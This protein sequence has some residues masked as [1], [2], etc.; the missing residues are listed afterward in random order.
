MSDDAPT[1]ILEIKTDKGVKVWQ[2]VVFKEWDLVKVLKIFATR[3]AI[4]A[5]R[6]DDCP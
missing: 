5:T 1:Y 2:E 4:G 6:N 3:M